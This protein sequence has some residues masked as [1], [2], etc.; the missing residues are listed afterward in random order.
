MLAK[1][2]RPF[3]LHARKSQAMH[4]ESDSAPEHRKHEALHVVLLQHGNGVANAGGSWHMPF[5]HAG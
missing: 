3:K 4:A 5:A 2:P 1:E